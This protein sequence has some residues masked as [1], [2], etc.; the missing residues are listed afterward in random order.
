MVTP[1][2]RHVSRSQA[3]CSGV[4]EV[5]LRADAEHEGAGLRAFRPG[6]E[7]VVAALLEAAAAVLPGDVEDLR[8]GAD[9]ELL[10]HV[11]APAGEG[12]R[13][14]QGEQTLVPLGQ[15]APPDDP[16]GRQQVLDELG[17]RREV[18]GLAA[19]MERPVRAPRA[20][21][22][23]VPRPAAGGYRPTD[24]AIFWSSRSESGGTHRRALTTHNA[25][26]ISS[27]IMPRRR[28]VPASEVRTS[29]RWPS[30]IRSSTGGAGPGL[31]SRPDAMT[32]WRSHSG[33]GAG[34]TSSGCEDISHS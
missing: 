16:L 1:S 22:P 33:N 6:A 24:V 8:E 31:L 5:E 4:S 15:A 25:P 17:D 2:F 14:V 27:A 13:H 23:S 26:R 20:S 10:R 19:V 3:T 7:D 34:G 28:M 21:C 29:L 12:E 30:E 32:S 18:P 11:G 9:E